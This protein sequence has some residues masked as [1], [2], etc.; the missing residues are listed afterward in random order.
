MRRSLLLGG[1]ELVTGVHLRGSIALTRRLF[2][3]KG[4]G[5]YVVHRK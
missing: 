1:A 4:Q 5:M 2:R 3:A